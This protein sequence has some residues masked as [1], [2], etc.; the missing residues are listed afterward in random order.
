ML[1]TTYNKSSSR[2]GS[3]FIEQVIAPARGEA[4]STME[5][6]VWKAVYGFEG[7]YEASSFG[8]IKSVSR[9]MRNHNAEWISS[10]R[11]LNPSANNA[12]RKSVCLYKGRKQFMRL[13]ATLVAEAFIGPRPP[14]MECCHNDGNSSNNQYQNLRWDT[15]TSNE[16]DKIAHGTSN[17]GANNGQSKLSESD[18]IAILA[19]PR[20]HREIAVDYNVGRRTIDRIKRG[21]SWSWLSSICSPTSRTSTPHRC[22]TN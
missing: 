13:V 11:I 18:V 16:A 12:G 21:E 6:E 14:G 17:R 20:I 8:R 4:C 5:E 19:D 9:P 2:Q 22:A 3:F 10:D 15:R 1:P 7:R